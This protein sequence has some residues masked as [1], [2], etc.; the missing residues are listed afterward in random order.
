MF[1]DFAGMS[2]NIAPAWFLGL[3]PRHERR[4][5]AQDRFNSIVGGLLADR[6]ERPHVG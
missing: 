5:I 1:A 3:K 2:T 4:T 6:E